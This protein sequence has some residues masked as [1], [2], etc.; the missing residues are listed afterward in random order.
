VKN[1]KLTVELVPESQ[2]GTNLRQVLS[3]K[4]WSTLR[5]QSYKAAEH[6]CEVCGGVGPRW[7]VECHEIWHYDDNNKIQRLDGL[8]S[9]CPPCHQ[10]KH[11]GRSFAIGR[12]PETLA[13]LMKVNE[14]KVDAAESY[15]QG[16]FETWRERSKHNWAL[17]LAWIDQFDVIL[18]I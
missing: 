12:G 16:V 1:I 15:I 7:P 5:K 11:M 9:L 8:I 2:W 10:V 14:W 17:D 3:K 13:H 4:D 6:K 18:N